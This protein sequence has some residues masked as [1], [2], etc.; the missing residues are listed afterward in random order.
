MFV[1][2]ATNL[3]GDNRNRLLHVAVVKAVP[4]LAWVILLVSS[5]L[6]SMADEAVLKATIKDELSGL[7]I[8]CSVTITDAEGKVVTENQAFKSGFRCSGQFSK[9]LP[10]G[11]T[12]IHVARGF[13]TQA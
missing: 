8:P 11:R 2:Q 10:A 12:R 3:P 7:P 9:R 4:G 1:V 6:S 13:E 5:P